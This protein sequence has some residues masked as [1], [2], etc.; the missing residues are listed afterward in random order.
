MMSIIGTIHE[1]VTTEVLGK[2][3]SWQWL[4][5]FV[6]LCLLI[7][8]IFNQYE[9]TLLL[10]PPTE[11]SCYVPDHFDVLNSTLCTFTLSGNSTEELK[12]TKWHVKLL[13]LIW[14]KKSWNIF[15]EQ[16]MKLLSTTIVCR[17]GLA[18]GYVIFGLV[19]DCFGRRK[20]ILINIVAEVGFRLILVFCDSANWFR[21]L[22]FLKSLFGSANFY[23][24]LVLICEIASNSWRSRLIAIVALPRVLASVCLVPL[25]NSGPNLETFNFIAFAFEVSLLL[26]LR[27]TPE[28]PQ[29]LLYNRKVPKTEEMLYKAAKMNCIQLCSNFKIRPVN[30]R[31]Y[32]CLDK[33]WTCVELFTTYNIRVVVSAI[34]SFWGL[35]FFLWS[36]L[37]VRAYSAEYEDVLWKV[38]GF[39]FLLGSLTLCLWRKMRVK[40][41][42][43]MTILF[44]GTFNAIAIITNCFEYHNTITSLISSL[45]LA[46]GLIGHTLILVIT[47]RLFAIN[48][49]A[50][51]FGCCNATAQLGTI[52]N[53]LILRF[54]AMDDLT[55]MILEVAV[56]FALCAACYVIPDVD[57]R[58]LPDVM[59]DMDYFSE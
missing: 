7:P 30:Y 38:F 21:L 37:Y 52:T 50:T 25:T 44:T 53:H 8:C 24:S 35:Y 3:G 10:Q 22:I 33:T 27:W 11:I 19:S 57:G 13:W 5:T 41:L 48:V 40:Q 23:M 18:F 45:A 1:D 26:L 58:E 20:A 49:R 2:M 4:T 14:I 51:L 43:L 32:N 12:C 59:E 46:S 6:S 9:D 54:R 56:T 29:W 39:I 16:P 28:S 34:L 31:A 15:C 47:P 55:L 36:S 42:L 17:L